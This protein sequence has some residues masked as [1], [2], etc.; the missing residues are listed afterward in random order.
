MRQLLLSACM[1]FGIVNCLMGQDTLSAKKK[2]NSVP[3]IQQEFG[4][5]ATNLIKQFFSFTDNNISISPY[6]FTYKLFINNTA[7]RTGLG[8]NFSN[9]E[10]E[11]DDF[12]GRI[13][14]TKSYAID[15]RLGIEFPKN[16]IGNWYVSFGLDFIRTNSGSHTEF[17]S[18]F[19]NTD[20]ITTS[21]AYGGGP[22]L[23][24]QFNINDKIN[25]STGST[26]Y[27]SNTKTT[28]ET[29]DLVTSSGVSTLDEDKTRTD[30]VSLYAPTSIFIAFRF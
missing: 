3:I 1:L 19:S 2:T 23:G 25:I 30:N 13:K 11:D 18:S 27:Y 7:L 22:F 5:N 12:G 28:V 15:Y 20:V 24:I 16:V 8:V 9:A 14:T 6:A 26:L 21:K 10:E 29:K 17:L 4:V